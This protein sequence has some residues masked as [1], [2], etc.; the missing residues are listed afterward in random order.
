MQQLTAAANTLRWKFLPN[1]LICLTKFRYWIRFR[2][3]SAMWFV[4]L[5]LRQVTIFPF[6]HSKDAKT[7]HGIR[8]PLN[9]KNAALLHSFLNGI[10][11]TV[12][13]VTS[14]LTFVLTLPSVR[15]CS[16]KPNR[17]MHR[18]PTCLKPTEKVSKE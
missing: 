15:L 1:G 7:V 11:K 2:H 14:V 18:S 10:Q 13:S 3:L 9:M 12:S 17:P 5:M 6:R 8:E 4:P 16:M